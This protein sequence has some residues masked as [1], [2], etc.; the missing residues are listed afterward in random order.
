MKHA[1]AIFTASL[2]LANDAHTSAADATA[3]NTSEFTKRYCIAC[4]DSKSKAAELDLEGLALNTATPATAALWERVYDKLDSRQM[5]PKDADQPTQEERAHL[6]ERLKTELHVASLARQ[7][8]EGRVSVRRLNRIEYENTLRDLLETHVHVR[9]ILPEDGSSAGFDNVGAALDTS[10]THL[11]R[12]QQAAEK[13]LS[14]AVTT[15]PPN[16][17]REKFTGKEWFDREVK[18]GRKAVPR[19]AAPD[20]EAVILYH[21]TQQ[22]WEMNVMAGRGPPVAR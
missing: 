16:I 9:D 18:G 10:S 1:I 22:H 4:H 7:Q 6:I 14:A 2:L 13:S 21:Q 12:Y 8:A 19:G 20:G 5:P 11:V 3:L 17:F 15:S